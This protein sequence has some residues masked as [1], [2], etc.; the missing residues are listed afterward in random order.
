MKGASVYRFW[1]TIESIAAIALGAIAV[2]E[3]HEGSYLAAGITGTASIINAGMC[4]YNFYLLKQANA[5]NLPWQ[6]ENTLLQ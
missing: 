6:Q 3:F 1:G 4:A 2:Y 5:K